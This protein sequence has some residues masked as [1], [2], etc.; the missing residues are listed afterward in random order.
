MS[1]IIVTYG[2][3]PTKQTKIL[4]GEKV[5]VDW[6]EPIEGMTK[7]WANSASAYHTFYVPSE[8][9]QSLFVENARAN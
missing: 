1:E 6:N 2:E 3:P 9:I 8:D 7:V 5:G 4:S